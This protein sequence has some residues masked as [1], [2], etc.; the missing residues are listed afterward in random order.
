VLAVAALCLPKRQSDPQSWS[1]R[2]AADHETRWSRDRSIIMTS[3]ALCIGD[4]MEDSKKMIMLAV[5]VF[6]EEFLLASLQDS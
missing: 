2:V 1:C 4:Q 6:E 3:I 5:V